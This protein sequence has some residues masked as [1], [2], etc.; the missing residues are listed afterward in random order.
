MLGLFPFASFQYI[1]IPAPTP[2]QPSALRVFSFYV[3]SDSR[4]QPQASFDCV[5]QY[6]SR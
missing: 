2:E 3:S 1:K 5:H 6:V 4:D